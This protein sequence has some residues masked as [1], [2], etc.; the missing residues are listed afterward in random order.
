MAAVTIH[1]I[2]ELKKIKSVTVSTVSPSICHEMMRQDAMILVFECWALSQ[3]FHFLLSLF[4]KRLFSSSL[5]L[6]TIRV[7]SSAYMRLL[8]F[9]PAILIL[10]TLASLF[11]SSISKELSPSMTHPDSWLR[12]DPRSP[13]YP[14]LDSVSL[15]ALVLPCVAEHSLPLG[16][17]GYIL[18]NGAFS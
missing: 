9:L 15:S 18:S 4:I 6:S 1:R 17:G 2:L 11:S 14:L 3:I 5:L 13:C 10:C 16:L 8:I 7:V 12:F